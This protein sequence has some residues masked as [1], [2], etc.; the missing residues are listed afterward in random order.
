MTRI[1]LPRRAAHLRGFGLYKNRFW[2]EDTLDA[3]EKFVALAREHGKTPVQLAL[4]W[5]LHNPVITAPIIS[6]SK[7]AQ[8]DDI[9]KVPDLTLSKE[10]DRGV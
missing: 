8:L 7:V 4:G 2:A 3:V 10:R 5:I 6:V 9:L 1:P